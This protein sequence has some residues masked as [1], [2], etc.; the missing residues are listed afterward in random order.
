MDSVLG[1]KR[2]EHLSDASLVREVALGRQD[3]LG[4]V[5]DCH[6]AMVLRTAYRILC[7]RRDAEDVTR[8]AFLKVWKCPY[9][10]ERYENIRLWLYRITVGLC[11]S[12]LRRRRLTDVLSI[13]FRVYEDQSPVAAS[14]EEE[15]ITKESWAIFCRASLML[16]PEQRVVYT[17][18]ELEMLS[19]EEV[20][21]ITGMSSE[22]IG[23]DLDAA[24]EAVRQELER[25]G[26]VR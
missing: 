9:D 10:S 13:R 16:S 4:V 21:V 7:D 23:N 17:L 18:I 1:N 2:H 22:R 12:C 24:V 3:A 14:P 5:M 11:H 15:F 26:K 19:M 25:Y 6:M 20:V 8:K